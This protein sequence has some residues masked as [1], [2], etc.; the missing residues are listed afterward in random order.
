[1]LYIL[2][3]GTD[4][5]YFPKGGA[6]YMPQQWKLSEFTLDREIHKD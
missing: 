3:H 5:A 2:Q 1:M 4:V 6:A